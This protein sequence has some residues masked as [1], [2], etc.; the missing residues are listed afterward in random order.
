MADATAVEDKYQ[1]KY[2]DYC[3]RADVQR[4]VEVNLDFTKQTCNLDEIKE[5][6]PTSMDENVDLALL[7]R[8]VGSLPRNSHPAHPPNQ[9][10]QA[11]KHTHRQTDAEPGISP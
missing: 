11:H 4:R 8:L 2:R 5:S 10:G 3:H 9:S 7:N 6:D 1:G